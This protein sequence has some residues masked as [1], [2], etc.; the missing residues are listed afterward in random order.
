VLDV[1][2]REPDIDTALLERVELGTPHIA[3]Y[4]FDGKVNGTKMIFD[5]ACRHFGMAAEWDPAPMMPQP[6]V[7]HLKVDAAAGEPEAVIAQVVRQIYDIEG[8][9]AAL[10]R[11]VDQPA[12]KRAAFFDSLRRGYQ[13]RRE[14]GNTEVGL[15]PANEA[16]AATF[17]ALGFRL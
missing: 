14:F 1:W 5:A 10:G 15:T 9:D 16:L 3:G 13:I 11:L 2:E 7:P 17:R 6:A 4:S 8:D 12:D